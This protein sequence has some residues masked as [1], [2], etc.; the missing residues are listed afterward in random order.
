MSKVKTQFRCQACGS[1]SPKWMGKCPDCNEWNKFVEEVVT[2]PSFRLINKNIITTRPVPISDITTTVDTRLKVGIEEVDRI[3]GGGIVSGSAILLGGPPGIGKSTL[4]L[5]VLGAIADKGITTLYIS[6][7]ESVEQIH[8]RAKRL[9][10]IS[11]NLFIA[12]ETGLEPIMAMM[13]EFRPGVTI[14]DSIQTVVTNFI[15]STPGSVSQLREC[16]TKLVNIVK[17]N[18]S[19]VF[20]VGHITKH[21]SIAG[22]MLLE[23]LVDVVLYFES[24]H[25][26][27]YRILRTNKNRYGT[28]N[29]IGV[30]Q[31]KGS[32]MEEV[33]NPSALFLSERT[34]GSSGSVVIASIEGTRPILVE[35]Q[36]LVSP[37]SFGVPRR[38]A[39]G[40]DISRANLLTAVLEKK[41]G[42]QL[43]Q[44]DIYLNVAGGVRILEPAI[45]LGIIAAINSSFWD[46]PV[47]QDTIIFGEVGLTGEV[48]AVIHPDLRLKE[49]KKLG[50]KR[51]VMAKS[52]G[53]FNDMPEV[54]GMEII[55]VKT[56]QETMAVL[57][58]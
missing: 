37:T 25:S 42:V 35:L 21:G 4:L 10:T 34:K 14:I 2:K 13:D 56:I 9:N 6:G 15:E 24:D 17:K 7:E 20:L 12:S 30:F 16:A 36:A 58:S 55:M 18:N 54:D 11:P 29:E 38:T 26:H 41:M 22:P 57:F 44:Q 39:I 31:M 52:N 40:V 32:G 47:P 28:T 5:Q 27:S 48:R 43:A 46:R 51:A 33:K 19:S 50:F 1:I 23:H 8:N 53:T 3:L 49:A 45:D